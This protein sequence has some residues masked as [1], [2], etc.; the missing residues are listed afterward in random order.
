MTE[1]TKIIPELGAE[2]CPASCDTHSYVQPLCGATAIDT[3]GG[4]IQRL[5][6]WAEKAKATHY[7]TDDGKGDYLRFEFNQSLFKLGIT[8]ID[9]KYLIGL[10]SGTPNQD[11]MIMKLALNRVLNV[12]RGHVSVAYDRRGVIGE[13]NDREYYLVNNMDAALTF[14]N[15][16]I[17]VLHGSDKRIMVNDPPKVTDDGPLV[18]CE[19]NLF[20]QIYYHFQTRNDFAKDM[21]DLS[22]RAVSMITAVL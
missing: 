18:L 8:Y 1:A 9:G 3:F 12:I 13:F 15:D 11:P 7:T 5:K 16:R 6:L 10:Y 4:A 22:K 21:A 17:D 19:Q 14:I 2:K 20:E